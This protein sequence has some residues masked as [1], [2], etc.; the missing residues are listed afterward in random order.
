[1]RSMHVHKSSPGV[2]GHK[3]GQCPVGPDNP[4][5][6][7]AGTP[8]ARIAGTGDKGPAEK[9]SNWEGAAEGGPL[10]LLVRN[11]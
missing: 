5:R 3:C 1:M 2:S 8:G 7:T 4:R 6:C 9:L 10:N 11:N